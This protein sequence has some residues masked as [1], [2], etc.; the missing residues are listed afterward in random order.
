MTDVSR[1][2]AD[3]ALLAEIS[4]A[5]FD[6]VGSFT[7][8]K[9]SQVLQ[10]L[11]NGEDTQLT[12]PSLLSDDFIN[13]W[14]VVHHQ[15]DTDSGFSA[16]LFKSKDQNAIQPYVL[17]IRGTQQGKEDL[18][19]T[20]GADIVLDGLAIDQI[21]DLYNY[22][23]KI[24]TPLNE[25]YEAVKL[26]T[27][28]AETAALALLKLGASFIPSFNMS[29]TA[30]RVYLSSR[31]DIIIDNGTNGLLGERVR[32]IESA[33]KALN[34]IGATG[35]GILNS[36]DLSSVTG[37]SL[38]GHL[39]AAFTRL[40]DDINI[41]AVTINGAGFATGIIPGL[42][43]D[44]GVNIRN[45]FYMLG[46]ADTFTPSRITNLFGDRYPEFVTQNGGL[47]L[48]QQGAHRA[49]Y[50]EHSS[51]WGDNAN[52]LGH[53]KEQMTN[54]LA[55]YDLFFQLD[56]STSSDPIETVLEK[57]LSLFY[58]ATPD[59]LNGN[60]LFSGA[61][62]TLE[63]VVNQLAQLF[64]ID[65]RIDKNKIDNREA[66]FNTIL[67]IQASST[68]INAVQ[69]NLKI[70]PL[71]NI[72]IDGDVTELSASDISA[73]A[74]ADTSDGLA[75]RYALKH[76]N[77]FVI[78]GD[79]TIYNPHKNNGNLDLYHPENNPNGMTPDYIADRTAML[80]IHLQ[81]NIA[82][83]RIATAEGFSPSTW[84]DLGSSGVQFTNNP[85]FDGLLN[86]E[87][88]KSVNRQYIIGSDDA[89]ILKG[90]SKEDHLYGGAGNDILYGKGGNDYLEG[91]QGFDLYNAG[92]GDTLFD[93]DGEG[94]AFL[95]DRVLTGGF[96]KDGDPANLYRSD[97]GLVTYQL[98][99]D[100]LTV[101]TATETL[102]VNHFNKDNAD[103]DIFLE[104]ITVPGGIL[105]L[106]NEDNYAPGRWEKDGEIIALFDGYDGVNGMGGNDTIFIGSHRT[107][108]VIRGG[109]GDDSLFEDE[110]NP[111]GLPNS[112]GNGALIFGEGGSDT[113]FGHN[114]SNFLDGGDQSDLVDGGG[115][116]DTLLGGSGG[117]IVVGGTGK[118]AVYGGEGH[119]AL[120]GGA[121]A[122]RLWGG[123]DNDAIYGDRS[124]NSI[125]KIDHSVWN[126]PVN[127]W[128]GS[129]YIQDSGTGVFS[130]STLRS[131]VDGSNYVYNE[132]RGVEAGNDIIFGESG[133]DFIIGGEGKDY[134]NGGIGRDL[135]EGEEGGDEIYGGSD[136]D[137]I[138][139]DINP[140]TYVNDTAVLAS[141]KKIGDQTWAVSYRLDFAG[142][143]Y[144]NIYSSD[145]EA[146]IV[147]VSN[148]YVN[149]YT[150]VTFFNPSSW[151]LQTRYTINGPDAGGNDKLYGEGGSD[152]LHGGV[153]DDILDGGD[154]GD[155][156]V[157]IGGKDNDTYQ[158]SR[159]YGTDI[160]QDE[161]GALDKILLIGGIFEQDIVLK[162]QGN[163]LLIE[164]KSD[165]LVSNTRAIVNDWYTSDSIETIEFTDGTVW[166]KADIERYTGKNTSQDGTGE[167]E[168]IVGGDNADIVQGTSNTDTIYTLGGN[169]L[170]TGGS[171]NDRLMG[172]DGND[173]LQG[174]YGN[175]LLYGESG[176]DTLFGQAGNDFL[177]GDEGNDKL[178]GGEGNDTLL[179]GIG[180]DDLIGGDGDDIYHF[181]RGD[182]V[183]YVLDSGGTDQ[184]VLGS[185]IGRNNLNLIRQGDTLN[186]TLHEQGEA[187]GDK[188]ILID[189]FKSDSRVESLILEDGTTLSTTDIEQL[190][191]DSHLLSQ[192]THTEGGA[193][194]TTYRFR[195]SSGLSEGFQITIEESSGYDRL[196]FEQSSMNTP[197]GIFYATPQLDAQTRDGSD[198]LLDLSI[199][200]QINA[201]SN[202]SG[203]VR[204]M[205][206]FSTEGYIE[207]ITFPSG[208][209]RD[210]NTA[211]VVDTEIPG[212]IIT[213]EEVYRFQL[214]A[215]TFV[216]HP[217]DDLRFGATLANGEPL[218]Q[219]L[220]FDAATGTFSGMPG[221]SDTE[222]IEVEVSATDALGLTGTTTFNLNVGNI[223]VAPV[224]TTE[225]ADQAGTE[226]VLLSYAI[227][228]SAFTDRNPGDTLT[229]SVT[230]GDGSPL[231]QWLSFDAGTAVISGTP[232]QEDI[233]GL[234]IL[235]TA[236]DDAGLA[237]TGS[238]HIGISYANDA[239]VIGS[240]LPDHDLT[241]NRA[242][243]FQLPEDGFADA[244][245]PFGDTLVY[246]ATQ[247]DGSALPP[248]MSF[249]PDT[250]TFNGR[251]RGIEGD[252]Q[253][254]IQVTATDSDGLFVTTVFHLNVA[255]GGPST[256]K[257]FQLSSLDGINGSTFNGVAES[258]TAGMSVGK[259][260]DFNGDGFADFIIGAPEADRFG[261][262]NTGEA[263]VVFGNASGFSTVQD[264]SYLNGSN[265]F[266]V[267]VGDTGSTNK[268][269]GEAVA[270]GGDLNGDGYDDIVIGAHGTRDS[271]GR[272]WGGSAHVIYG[273]ADGFSG[274]LSISDLDGVNGFGIY[275]DQ[276]R[277]ELSRHA[278]NIAGD[279]NDDG[280][281]DLIVGEFRSGEAHI[282]FGG[283]ALT[284]ASLSVAD[285]DG[286]NGFTVSSTAY[287]S[288]GHAVSGVGDINGDGVDDI[289]IGAFAA[290]INPDVTSLDPNY[291]SGAA[292]V[293]FGKKDDF[294]ASLDVDDLN[295]ENGFR[296][297]GTGKSDRVGYSV[298][299]GGD[300]NGDGINDIVIGAPY[301]ENGSVGRSGAAYVVFGRD[302]GF[303][304]DI[305]VAD[306]NGQNGFK[307]EGGVYRNHSGFSVSHAGD[308]NTDGLADI[309]IGGNN[310]SV[311]GEPTYLVFGQTKGFD[312]VVNLEELNGASGLVITNQSVDEERPGRA[313]SGIGDVNGDGF[314]DLLL[315]VPYADPN[316]RSSGEAH[317]V[318]GGDFS[319]AIDYLGTNADEVVNVA[320]SGQS[321]F[322]GGGDDTINIGQVE[323]VN[324]NVGTGNNQINFSAYNTGITSAT[325]RSAPGSSN[326]VS[327]G[328][329]NSP[330]IVQ[331]QNGRYLLAMPGFNG[332][333]SDTVYDVWTGHDVSITNDIK[334]KKGSLIVDVFDGQIEL[335]FEGVDTSNLLNIESPFKSIIFNG[336]QAVTYQD[337]LAHGFDFDGTGGADDFL[338]TE[339]VDRMYGLEGEDVLAGGSGDDYL[340]GGEGKD[341]IYGGRGNDFLVG[342]KADD[343]LDGGDGNDNYYVQA[344]DG[345]DRINESGGVDQVVFSVGISVADITALRVDD[346]LVLQLN[347][348]DQLAITGWFTNS[349]QQIE[350]F[351]FTE[352]NA[353][354]ATGSQVEELINGGM[355]NR[356]PFVA[357]SITDQEVTESSQFNF[358]IP[359]Q[360]FQDPDEDDSLVYEANL[361]SGIALPSWLNFNAAT[362]TFDGTPGN[363]DIGVLTI[364]VTATDQG[365]SN[366][367]SQFGLSVNAG[368]N[369]APFVDAG[370]IDQQAVEDA[371]FSFSVPSTTFVDVD[372]LNGD[373]L[374]LSAALADG[375][376][377]PQWLGFDAVTQTFSGTPL[378]S[379]VGS[380]DVRVIATDKAG[381]SVS[382][383]FVLSVAN[384]ND[385]PV[386]ANDIIDRQATE[387]AA[388]T[389]TVPADT[390]RDDDAIHGD[391]LSL[392]ATLADGTALPT[393]LGFDA[394]T[395]TFSGTAL[396]SDVGGLEVRVTA[397]DQTGESE[398]SDFVLSVENSNDA[399][400]VTN[401]VIG[402]QAT[403]D[404]TFT[405]TV[406]ADIFTDDDVIHGDTLTLSATLA[407][408][409]D[410]PPWLSF[411]AA[412]QVFSGTP[413]N[414]DVGGLEVRVT[415]TDQTGESASSDF[416]LSVE[417]S[418]DTPVVTNV[419][420]N[421]QA[422]EDITFIFTVPADTFMDDDAIHGD[423][424]TLS[425][426]LADGTDLPSWLN[427]DTATQTFSGTPQNN[428][429]GSLD[430][431][432][433][434][435][436]LDGASV[437]S[438]LSLQVSNSNDAPTL[439]NSLADMKITELA[440][441][442]VGIPSDTFFDEDAMH[443]DT[444]AYSV[445]LENGDELPGWLQLHNNTLVGTAPLDAPAELDLMIT[446]T[447][448]AG[449]SVVSRFLL[450]ITNLIQGDKKNN[451]L[452]G[453]PR[454][455][456]IE[457][458]AGRD[459][460][461]D[462]YQADNQIDA[463]SGN[464]FVWSGQ[465][466]DSVHGGA[467]N[468]RII[469][470]GGDDQLK[471]DE[472]NDRLLGG[473][474]DDHLDGG[475]GR[476]TI[477]GQDGDD[478]LYGG[479]GRDRLIGGSGNDTYIFGIGDGQDEIK[480]S[481]GQDSITLSD[482][483]ISSDLW[484]WRDEK[485][486]NMGII[487]TSD[488]LVVDDWFKSHNGWQG[489]HWKYGHE[490]SEAH[491]IES[492]TTTAGEVLRNNQVLSL[493]EAMASFDPPSSGRIEPPQELRDDVAATIAAVWT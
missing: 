216:D 364:E 311:Q 32:T 25:S 320:N 463:G 401:V 422:T 135:L 253:F 58:T 289:V 369:H 158:F 119:D 395:Q 77:P 116:D 487:G 371:A 113:I 118:D 384:A 231:P 59:D 168:L 381:K 442:S 298:S 128:Q 130:F 169:D 411:D 453:S 447:D 163:D 102:T 489:R 156:D 450:S 257:E 70:T 5:H 125:I 12:I 376:A 176:S 104:E 57:Y 144:S 418:N 178:Y 344:G 33:N 292:Y 129:R 351:V 265:G 322:S 155:I 281:D 122:D 385:A 90:G 150:G 99:G 26:V 151:T 405:F 4:Y 8:V 388:F 328:S 459:T 274:S 337:I 222:I 18:V 182:G 145:P 14:S 330:I 108:F 297:S 91:G 335:H 421:Q 480:D 391:S 138:Y 350:K 43:L 10:N 471:G 85:S 78:L 246:A 20:D 352:D 293:V 359:S 189:W 358:K 454:E 146:R 1:M 473:K 75:Y 28:K 430:V 389:F 479:L 230:Q 276:L 127:G 355:I 157:L 21:V 96:H 39:A 185:G 413:Q 423:T 467:G 203:N 174:S 319:G 224:L 88:H 331:S 428:D 204:I 483:V 277:G 252:S 400:V 485:D 240:A 184:I 397:T 215:G 202:V 305:N 147:S 308:V 492:I 141:G 232:T 366:T 35:V 225:L 258:D 44:A 22:W 356:A 399:P 416:V 290:D 30:F 64:Y 260:G 443:G 435:T 476:D 244:D 425:A 446:A 313:V 66:L 372:T 414:S 132:A 152:E 261:F 205:N 316:G 259:A 71:S 360:T 251:P 332:G 171:G 41:D 131:V 469:G 188:L 19:I 193:G 348:N 284:Q 60:P 493:V 79:E 264:L 321:I 279:I 235:V 206:F 27:L 68:F 17:S 466:N 445:S 15:E 374:I 117:D 162:Q 404:A 115:G 211:P 180:D 383:D 266:K 342:G 194:D 365:G 89:D 133:D 341:Q 63:T 199:S 262:S 170:A 97:D 429:V 139:G 325:I 73:E 143:G 218:P 7:D 55:V 137:T 452:F 220:Q 114:R 386:V 408:G 241:E 198:L 173:E 329:A 126:G 13:N 334:L 11:I 134:I 296:I 326:I 140:N 432:V 228:E 111:Q 51:V 367:S 345:Q 80:S 460:I 217:A 457:G 201:I 268:R 412:T 186:I 47:G 23:K 317:V 449:S 304:V 270:G 165:G 347:N 200:S 101:S 314:D 482:G 338:G 451:W 370:I 378:N 94:I 106:N 403:E 465:G 6:K 123:D 402:Q 160:I 327:F 472:G 310:V 210:L 249:N 420:I 444:L 183:D 76:L 461:V 301:A 287:S 175:D 81:K 124:T 455:D 448:L 278:V 390:F 275:G 343:Y 153:G 149:F 109:A 36:S 227:P 65:L 361:E 42:G 93:S 121:G 302:N 470:A 295:G 54:S 456:V 40:F 107:S 237:D 306:L 437:A 208:T 271:N 280:F 172:G 67:A 375:T 282:I 406:P 38:G 256:L 24:T 181:N 273:K 373:T 213:T 154:G 234:D 458:F 69:S 245:M 61:N 112:P 243:S 286:S 392:T 340:D 86:G 333:G 354:V 324:L 363:Q 95:N 98:N 312:P 197:F 288:L 219:W 424:L 212:Q 387:D 29:A 484:F 433:I 441:F 318:F 190:V 254:D 187:V 394:V 242:F 136:D 45:L 283:D 362:Q 92:G 82:D 468:D 195:P 226:G 393:W 247:A 419:V 336:S 238:F 3:L 110:Q 474:G 269:L 62:A 239:P 105:N 120:S 357:H 72:N 478:R 263:Y 87:L 417:N 475:E 148:G 491:H 427:F 415:A 53:G 74:N 309:L 179:G 192:D 46:G 177:S 272:A 233:G 307:I 167:T 207:Q 464:D 166:D 426:T 255:E 248:W 323:D 436:D 339:V 346:D 438:E 236:E 353:L 103:L 349:A 407:D 377:L 303:A 410:L 2:Y 315:G 83:S 488:R 462:F 229:Y 223:N 285:L 440:P 9:V 142:I 16:T 164:L 209:L 300:I 481:N 159:G 267:D 431:R 382:S 49:V 100:T 477:Y 379:D 31:T 294:T 409:T 380:L 50:I 37:H 434:A 250:L 490:E 34:D 191:A 56:D 368:T 221:A 196:Q 52:L 214:P 396:N 161:A 299:G 486:L 398:S 439:L 84:T 291:N 48:F